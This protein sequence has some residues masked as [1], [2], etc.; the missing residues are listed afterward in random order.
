MIS[1][2][3]SSPSI[4][5]IVLL[6]LFSCAF[7]VQLF[8]SLF[9]FTK[10]ISYSKKV[11][12]GLV[13]FEESHP[14][15]SIIICAKNESENLEKFLP[16][17]LEQDYPNFEIIVVNDG[18]SD[19]SEDVLVKLKQRY[20]N[21]QT[22]FVPEIAKFVD[23]KKFAVVLGIKAAKN[24][25]LLFTDADC[26]PTSKNWI[27]N[28]VRNFDNET[29]I[30]LGYGGYSK[31]K[32]FLNCLIKYD[33]L[34]IAIQYFNYALAKKAYMGVGR[35]M[36]YRK[37]M[38]YRTKGFSSHLN[39]QSGDDDLFINE[40]TSKT[41]TRIEISEDSTTLS[42]PKTTLKYWFN[43][44]E[45]HLSTSRH[46]KFQ[47]KLLIATEILSRFLFYASMILALC[48]LNPL[49]SIIVGSLFLIR[50]IIQLIIINL[51]AKKLG[52][53]RFYV[54]I[55]MFDILLPIF[56]LYLMGRSLLRGKQKYKWK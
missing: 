29:E 3:E 8:Y 55:L 18:S 14:P 49:V 20:S 35:N 27:T 6:A 34:F 36:A 7:L 30:V 17:V 13:K 56:N 24:E 50:Y 9:Y 21:L 52:E 31:A 15:V 54:S 23:S 4:F 41:N 28:M 43:Q 12:K 10:M 25:L 53:Q 16:S 45:R 5:E 11:K 19:D 46:Y 44:K 32:G 47:S 40:T 38:F 1:L 48:L 26:I 22:T 39:L 2:F 33:T 42:V 37:S 51:S